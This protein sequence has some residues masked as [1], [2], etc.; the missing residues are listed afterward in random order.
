MS[1]SLLPIVAAADNFPYLPHTSRWKD[2]RSPPTPEVYIPFYLTAEDQANDVPPVGLIRPEVLECMRSLFGDDKEPFK[3][4][5]AENDGV[6]NGICFNDWVVKQGKMG[7]VMNEISVKWRDEGKF[8]GP[9]GGQ[10]LPCM[11]ADRAYVQVGGTSII[12]SLPIDNHQSSPPSP[13]IA[14]YP[15]RHSPLSVQHVPCLA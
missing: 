5:S 7:Q 13:P 3:L 12:P 8:P 1:R 6:H 4:L 15:M 14:H 11:V 2:A 10:S 9:L